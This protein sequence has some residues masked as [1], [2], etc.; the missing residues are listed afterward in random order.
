MTL[1]V[2]GILIIPADPSIK[3]NI[4]DKGVWINF[5]ALS[6]INNRWNCSIWVNSEE[7]DKWT[8]E[9]LIEGNVLYIRDAILEHPNNKFLKV[10]LSRDS[11]K[12]INKEIL[13]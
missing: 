11:V 8:D 5:S 1:S 10:K 13:E 4:T 2:H 9:I 3:T 7:Q 12:R 6:D